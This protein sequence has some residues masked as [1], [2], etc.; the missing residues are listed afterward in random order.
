MNTGIKSSFAPYI[1][2][3]LIV[4]YIWVMLENRHRLLSDELLTVEEVQAAEEA[5]PCADLNQA[6]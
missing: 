2:T 6:G 5:E 3:V 1:H 4:S